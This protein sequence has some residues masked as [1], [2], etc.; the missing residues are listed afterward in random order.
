V[1]AVPGLGRVRKALARRSAAELPADGPAD[2]GELVSPLR[3]DILVRAEYFTFLAERLEQFE[4]D[5]EGFFATALTH[6]YYTWF[7]T[8]ALPRFRPHDAATEARRQ[9]AYRQRLHEAASLY[10]SVQARGYDGVGHPLLLRAAEPG[11]RTDSGKLVPRRLYAGDGCHRL[12]LLLHLGCR[13]LPPEWYR[14]RRVARPLD[15]TAP[16]LG[17]L[18]VPAAPYYRFLALGYAGN[19]DGDGDGVAPAPLP[20]DREALLRHVAA[21][22]PERLEELRQ[23]LAVDEPLLA[24]ANPNRGVATE[25]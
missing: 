16:L 2:L 13:S 17:A 18:R 7:T 11:A 1:V 14:I 8:I 12:A 6:P 23:V 22:A 19:R 21:R 24:G 9:A 10:R 15:N 4:A 5:F 3:Y 20:G 25:S